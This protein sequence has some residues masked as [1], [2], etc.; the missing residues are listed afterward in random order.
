MKGA[1]CLV[2]MLVGVRHCLGCYDAPF[3]L[4]GPSLTFNLSFHLCCANHSYLKVKVA[5][6]VVLFGMFAVFG[7]FECTLDVLQQHLHVRA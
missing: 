5:V 4:S 3:C 6:G 2:Q 7:G 1:S